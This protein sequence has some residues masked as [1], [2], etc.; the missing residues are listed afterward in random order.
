M[1]ARFDA[2]SFVRKVLDRGTAIERDSEAQ[3]RGYKVHSAHLDKVSREFAAELRPHLAEHPAD[4]AE[5][6]T[7]GWLEDAGFAHGGYCGGCFQIRTEFGQWLR[8][9]TI[10]SMWRLGRNRLPDM[11]TRGEVRLLCRAL[12]IK[13]TSGHRTAGG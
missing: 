11:K 6:W 7:T 4:D 8:V 13:L 5:P 9:L 12:K 2:W 1:S 3:G 10:N